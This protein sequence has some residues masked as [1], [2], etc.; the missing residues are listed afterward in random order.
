L[1]RSGPSPRPAD[2]SSSP[3]ACTSSRRRNA[4]TTR[5]RRRSGTRSEYGTTTTELSSPESF[6]RS[7]PPAGATTST[8]MAVVV[9]VATA[10]PR[11]PTTGR[12]RHTPPE[13]RP[14]LPTRILPRLRLL[15]RKCRN[16][17]HRRRRCLERLRLCPPHPGLRLQ[18]LAQRRRR[19]RPGGP[20]RR[21]SFRLL[22]RLNAVPDHRACSQCTQER[23]TQWC[24]RCRS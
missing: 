2:L 6:R 19:A 10:A 16:R 23:R 12:W 17:E 22:G 13:R 5:R 4:C 24:R 1:T 11:G 7:F 14:F 9:K 15:R 20:S 18:Y 3:T 8:L 21:F